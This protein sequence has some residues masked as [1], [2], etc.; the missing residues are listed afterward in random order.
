MAKT[1]VTYVCTECGAEQ[2]QWSGQCRSCKAWHTISET[3]VAPQAVASGGGSGRHAAWAGAAQ[4]VRQLRTSSAEPLPR[5]PSGLLEFDRVLGGGLVEGSV[6]LIAGDP[7]IGKSTLLLQSAVA[8]SAHQRVLYVAGE[9]SPD[10]VDLRA[11]RLGI[12]SSSL[13]LASEIDMVGIQT[14]LETERPDVAI[15]DSIQTV[16]HPELASAPGT[17]AQV[18]EC[19]AHLTRYAKTTGCA[20]FLVGHVT[21]EGTIAGPKTLSHMVDAELYFEGEPGTPFRLLRALKN[22]FGAVNEIGI[23]A[24]GERGLEEVSNP[25]SLFLTHHEE[26]VSGC[27]VL[28]A[29]E[30]NR[31]LF[32]EVQALIEEAPTPNP[33]RYAAGLDTNRL[34]LL[35]AVLSKHGRVDA[36]EKNVYLKAVGGIRLTEPAADLAALLALHSSLTDNPLPKDLVTFGEVGLAGELRPVQDMGLRLREA[37]KLGFKRAIIPWSK[38]EH[39]VPG[40]EVISL[41]RIADVIERLRLRRR[42]A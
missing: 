8:L 11:A 27:A 18:R 19:A 9:E 32:V 16:Y 3:R 14:V 5:I 12:G 7:G 41:R 23:F 31:P 13:R 35:L 42:A 22:R 1:K 37:A 2:E 10:Q 29:M 21:K 28:A 25:S 15:I 6:L 26:P 38:E 34:Q 30:G 40:L 4:P 39:R 36:S 24:M 17:V 33:K 20:I